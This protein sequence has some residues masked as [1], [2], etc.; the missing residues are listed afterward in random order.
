MGAASSRHSLRPLACKRV[1]L[2]TTRAIG[3]ARARA[4]VLRQFKSLTGMRD[5]A[6]ASD[7]TTTASCVGSDICYSS[8]RP[9][10]RPSRRGGELPR[11]QPQTSHDDRVAAKSPDNAAQANSTVRNCR[12]LH[13]ILLTRLG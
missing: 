11:M 8:A 9:E 5:G 3:A 1:L 6:P 10:A 2:N 7:A 4:L 12:I 13:L